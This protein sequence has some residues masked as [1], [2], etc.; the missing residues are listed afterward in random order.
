MALL[1]RGWETGGDMV[2]RVCLLIR[3]RVAGVALKRKTLELP[4]RGAFVA[5]VTW[6]RGVPTDQ[7][8]PVLVIADSLH[9][10]LPAFY[11]MAPIAT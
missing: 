2:G 7:G 5:T 9:G 10:D 6:Q 3:R 1:A 8:K 4:N 11:R